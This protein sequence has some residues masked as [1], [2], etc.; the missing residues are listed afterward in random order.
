M[1]I[2]FSTLACPD[3]NIGQAVDIA[4]QCGYEGIELRFLQGEDSLWKLPD[5]QG[6]GLGRTKQRIRDAG[7]TVCCVDT[8]CRFDSPD[9]EE[10]HRWIEEGQRMA[11]LAEELGAPGIRVF[12]D[13]IQEGE[14]REATQGWIVECLGSLSGQTKVGVWLETHGDFSRSKDVKPIISQCEKLDVIWDPAAAF[15]EARERPAES[16]QGIQTA[17]RHVHIKD[18]RWDENGRWSPILTGEGEFPLAEMKDSMRAMNYEGFLSFEWEKKW[19]PEI[20]PAEIALPQFANWFRDKWH[21]LE[22]AGTA[23]RTGVE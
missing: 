7:L 3:W 22:C 10:R 11:V 2:S 14:S 17:I 6:A 5:F 23:H 12:G 9:A 1:K 15:V 13:R 18:L 8:S 16:S 20:E 19:H 21:A 4:T